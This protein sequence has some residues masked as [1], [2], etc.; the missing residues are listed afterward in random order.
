METEE[1]K[2]PC[3]IC[4]EEKCGGKHDCN[5]K[6]C[7]LVSECYRHL[8]PTIR[9]TNR[10]TQECS[11]C[12]FS[13][14]P[15]SNIMMSVEQS[16]KIA[17]FLKNNNIMSANLMGGE[18]F[19]NPN[20]FEILSNFLNVVKV[21]RLVTNGDWVK[22]DSV[23]EK[24]TEFVSLY[25]NKI[26]FSISKDKWHTNKN[27]DEAAKFFENLGV[28]YNV[29]TEE[30]T[31]DESIVPVGRSMFTYN[32]FSAFNC[33]CHNPKQKYSFLIDEEGF[34]YKCGFGILK[35]ADIDDYLDGGFNKRF[36]AFNSK[37]YSIFISNCRSCANFAMYNKSK[38][39][40]SLTVKTN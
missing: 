24:L 7:K 36:K 20:W 27:V 1:L 9:I 38:D 4:L 2:S 34:I 8:H 26:H 39:G 11:H 19:C 16:D 6:T 40:L 17:Q 13:S 32:M 31:K 35:Y 23:K 28:K 15:K 12:C 3:D 18:F 5:C 10:C 14:S 22:S 33:Y 30:E 37:F 29:A 25:K 21:A